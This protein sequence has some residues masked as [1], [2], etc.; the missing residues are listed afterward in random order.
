MYYAITIDADGRITGRHESTMALTAEIFAGGA[1]D[2]QEVRAVDAATEYAEGQPLAAYD[3][4]G[5]LRPIIDRIKEGLTEV[6][7]G[8]ELV[9]DE[10]VELSAPATEAPPTLAQLVEKLMAANEDMRARLDA[11][12]A[13]MANLLEQY[14]TIQAWVEIKVGDTIAKDTIVISAFKRYQAKQEHKKGLLIPAMDANNWA[15]WEDPT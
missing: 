1:F 12:F 6:P 5:M 11:A 7:Q 10:L 9:G 2:G 15:A 14:K 4:A 3:P 13:P 8:F